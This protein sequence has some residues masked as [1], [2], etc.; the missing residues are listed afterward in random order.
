MS[1]IRFTPKY[2][3][4]SNVSY[5]EFKIHKY[6]YHLG[7]VNIPRIVSYDETNKT[8]KI[9]RIH[10]SSIADFYGENISD[11]PSTV[12]NSISCILK[13]LASNKI[14]YPDITGYNFIIDEDTSEIWIIDFEHAKYNENIT[15]EFILSSCEKIQKWNPDFT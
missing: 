15:D 7:I 9:K 3:I 5:E 8:M 14:E 2:V 10:G 12:L 4:K 11:I 13:N 1:N 6:V